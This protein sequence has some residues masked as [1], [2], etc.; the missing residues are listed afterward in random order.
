MGTVVSI[1]L[2]AGLITFIGFY[3]LFRRLNRDKNP[4]SNPLYWISSIIGSPIL[5][6][7][8]IWVWFLISS[9]Y[10]EKE[11]DSK[12]W[13]EQRE[14]RYEYVDDLV[15][16]Q[17]AIGLEKSEVLEKMG[18]PDNQSDTSLTYYIGYTPKYFMNMDPDWLEI[19]LENNIVTEAWIAL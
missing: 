14:T 4:I 8:I 19:K 2:L 3:F 7:G 11:F 5:L 16:E 15:N 17:K 10:E 9:N 6:A 12:A 1:L 13:I 18:K